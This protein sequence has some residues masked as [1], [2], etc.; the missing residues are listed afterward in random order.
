LSDPVYG[1]EFRSF[2]QR[3]N[4]TD[5][6]IPGGD[7][8]LGIFKHLDIGRPTTGGFLGGL[9]ALIL[10]LAAIESGIVA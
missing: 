8:A 7:K 3:S 10:H 4:V 5:T 6:N 2:A 1:R 9:P